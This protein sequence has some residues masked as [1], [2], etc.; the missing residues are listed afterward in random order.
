MTA[1]FFYSRQFKAAPATADAA[2]AIVIV[3]CK[4]LCTFGIKKIPTTAIATTPPLTA[5]TT[6]FQ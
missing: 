3:K 5:R 2:A 4:I 1:H 6:T